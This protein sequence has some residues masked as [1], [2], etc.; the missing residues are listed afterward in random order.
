[1]IAHQSDREFK[2]IHMLVGIVTA[3]VAGVAMVALIG[4]VAGFAEVRDSL[5]DARFQWLVVCVLGQLMVFAGYAGAFRRTVSADG[6][7]TVSLGVSLRVVLASFAATQVFSFGGIGGLAVMYWVLRRFERDAQA[8]AVR[9]IGLN[10]AVYL[11]FGTIGWCAAAVALGADGAPLGMTVS[12][13]VGIPVV[14]I[15]ARWFTAPTRVDRWL[16]ARPGAIRRAFATGLG[17]AVWVRKR[18]N[19]NDSRSLFYWAACYWVGD[20]ACLWAALNAFGADPGLVPLTAA[21]TTGYLVQSVP[22]PL[23]ATAGVDTA[24]TLLLR[25]VGVPLD[26]ALLGVVTHRVF[27]FWIPLVP[28]SVFALTISRIGAPVRGDQPYSGS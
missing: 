13:L 20:I 5:A 2:P 28:G 8:A 19:D 10:T 23:I 27:A 3:A 6:G 7:P 22:I 26:L 18:L 12:W 17:A 9:L 24:T 14:V 1:V 25:T 15:A 11:V 16:E 21:Y 4:R